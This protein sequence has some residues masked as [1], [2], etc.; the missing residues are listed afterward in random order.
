MPVRTIRDIVIIGGG[1]SA[2]LIAWNLKR[3]HQRSCTIIAPTDRP[4]FGLAYATPSLKNLLNVAASGM[5]ADPDDPGHFVAWMRENVS[6]ETDPG[7]FVP[8][9]IFGLYLRQLYCAAAPEHIRDT[10]IACAKSDGL[11]TITLAGGGTVTARQVVLACGHFDPARLPGVPPEIDAT[12]RYHHD[13]WA[14]G[15]FAGIGAD[16][17]VVLIGTGL[18]AVDVIMRLR[19][20]GHRGRIT[21]V[22]RRGLFPERHAPHAT[23]AAPVFAP[24]ATPATARAY[25]HAFHTALRGG[26]EW[27]AAVDSMRPVVNPLWL[28]LPDVEKRR[29]RRHLQRRW[30]IRRH[31]MAPTI[32]DIIDAER[33]VGTLRVLDGRI[34]AIVAAGD[35]LRVAARTGGDRLDVEAAHVINCTGPSLDYAKAASPLLRTMLEAGTI[36]PGFGGAGLRCTPAGALFDRNGVPAHDL[37]AIGPARLGVLFESIAIPEIRQQARDLAAL[38]AHARTAP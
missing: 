24:G 18:T 16:E 9:P 17:E 28:A 13:A 14:D 35:R 37:H 23:L 32:A 6:A 20:N 19:E 21:T 10:A 22:S 2:A 1:A 15:V 7:T 36:V 12:G 30:E 33:R 38:L 8:R 5:S 29:F 34:D 4:A 26:T 3:L 31:R 27:R 25:L 11:Y